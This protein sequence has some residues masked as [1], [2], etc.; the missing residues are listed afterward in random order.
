MTKSGPLNVKTRSQ[1]IKEAEDY[2]K[3]SMYDEYPGFLTRWPKINKSLGKVIPFGRIY[4][5]CGLSGSGKS[6]YLNM[7]REDLADPLLNEHM[8][9]KKP[10]KILS[11]CFEMASADEIIRTLSGK[12]KTSYSELLSVQ[13]QISEDF[14]KQ[15][16]ETSKEID[17]DIVH[18]VE[19]NGNVKNMWETAEKFFLRDYPNHRPII[20]IDH[21]TLTEYLSESGETELVSNVARFCRLCKKRLGAL[22]VPLGQLRDDIEKAERRNNVSLHYPTRNDIYGGK[23]LYMDS[24]YV[25]II[26]RPYKIGIREYGPKQLKTRFSDGSDLIAMHF[27]KGRFTG[28]EGLVLFKNQFGEGTLQCVDENLEPVEEEE[29][30]SKDTL[31]SDPFSASSKELDDEN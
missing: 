17:N 14:F 23:S 7:L 20:T 26:H 11:F 31:K 29:N 27:L 21:T 18:Y 22:V 25:N 8:M 2:I 6:Y 10:Y 19:D 24:D 15:I 28:T 3:E 12:L 30:K 9:Y 1:A 16:R 5:I 13:E 4:Y